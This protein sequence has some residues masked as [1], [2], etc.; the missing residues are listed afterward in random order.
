MGSDSDRVDALVSKL[1]LEFKVRD[2]G[3]P[4]FFLG[5]ETVQL[6]SGMLLSQQRY[7]KDIL[8]RAGMVDCKPV[9][10]P[11]SSAKTVD[12]P[13]VPYADPTHYHSLAGALQYLTV[14]R[15]DL[16][17]AVNRLCQHMHAPTTADWATLK[18]VLHY[19]N[20]TLNLGVHISLSDYF[21]I[22]AYSDSDWAGNPDDQKS[23]SC[24]VVF[25][26]KNLIS[27][28]CRKQRTVAR[29]STEAE[30]KGLAD[31]SAEVT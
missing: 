24:F 29:S 1:A 11:I 5:I 28:V 20:G 25:L 23:T 31:V 26:G 2:M 12:N 22:H 18:R 19:V 14:T 7:M 8:K 6:S 27:L 4:S 17:Y 21:D 30:Y 15:P 9:A 3:V 13:V 10:T 16:S